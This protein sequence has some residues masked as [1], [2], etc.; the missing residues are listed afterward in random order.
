MRQYAKD[1]KQILAALEEPEEVPARDSLISPIPCTTS[2]QS[3]HRVGD[4]ATNL[5]V[6]VTQ[7]C[8]IASYSPQ[9]FNKRLMTEFSQSILHQFGI[10]YT[11][12]G[13]PTS[14]VTDTEIQ[15]GQIEFQ[16]AAMALYGLDFSASKT[17]QL[18]EQIAGKSRQATVNILKRETGVDKITLDLPN[19]MNSLPTDTTKI[20]FIVIYQQ[21]I[22]MS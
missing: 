18:S 11:L 10:G 12:L 9:A 16:V 2:S 5:S 22:S 1:M 14:H 13:S 3:N 15:P 4:E 21:E 8:T 20:H 7:N 17:N 19:D 6:T